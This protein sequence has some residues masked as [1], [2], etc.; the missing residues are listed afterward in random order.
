MGWTPGLWPANF[1]GANL[2][3]ASVWPSGEVEIPDLSAER[4][5]RVAAEDRYLD[6]DYERRIGD[7]AAES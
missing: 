7:V 2:W 5:V 4:T 1:W 6:V 3:G